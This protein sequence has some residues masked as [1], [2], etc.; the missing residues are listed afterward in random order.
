MMTPLYR[1]I[2]GLLI[3]TV[4]LLVACGTAQPQTFTIG[5]VSLSGLDHLYAGFTT[6]MAEL[7]YVEGENIT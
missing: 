4:L 3:Y 5:V 2:Y 1:L 6:G 7:G